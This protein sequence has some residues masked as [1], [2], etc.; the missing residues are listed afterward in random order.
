M[1]KSRWHLVRVY[2]DCES[3]LQDVSIATHRPH[4]CSNNNI[5]IVS[6]WYHET[7]G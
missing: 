1:I 7:S 5:N 2:P 3:P 4:G 6:G